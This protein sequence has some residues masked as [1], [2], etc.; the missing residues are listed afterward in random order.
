M[1][2]KR[3]QGAELL[4]F[5]FGGKSI[6][7]ET[8][9]KKEQN[10]KTKPNKKEKEKPSKQTKQSRNFLYFPLPCEARMGKPGMTYYFLC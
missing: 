4:I 7:A 10:Q 3:V 5:F 2:T 9:S 1:W 6:K 8:L